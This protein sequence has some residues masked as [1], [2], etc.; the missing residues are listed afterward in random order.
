MFILCPLNQWFR[1]LNFLDIFPIIAPVHSPIYLFTYFLCHC[2][3]AKKYLRLK[4]NS[5]HLW[6][7]N[8]WTIVIQLLFFRE[9]IRSI[10]MSQNQSLCWLVTFELWP[11]HTGVGIQRNKL[12]KDCFDRVILKNYKPCI[13][14]IRPL[15][16]TFLI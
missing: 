3:I 1:C 13:S 8:Y 4:K 12:G 6:S 10:R 11:G 15:M 2:K 5:L 16:K 7:K 9:S 14:K